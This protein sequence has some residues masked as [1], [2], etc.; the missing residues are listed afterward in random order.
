MTVWVMALA[1]CIA[2]MLSGL[3]LPV[4]IIVCVVAL[5]YAWFSVR[6]LKRQP[7]RSVGWHGDDAWTLHLVDGR[8]ASGQLLSGRVLG[9][10]IVLRLAWPGGARS[11]LTLLPDSVDADTRRRLRVRLSALTDSQ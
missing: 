2:V 8:E 10:L 3:A 9:P 11:T 5:A 6:K 1:A 4:R 7:L